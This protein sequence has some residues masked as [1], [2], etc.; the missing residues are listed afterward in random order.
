M[1]MLPPSKD[2]NPNSH[3]MAYITQDKVCR[4]CFDLFCH[5]F[6]VY[7]ALLDY[8]HLCVGWGSDPAS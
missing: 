4:I 1:L 3:Y 7:L 5:S 8:S 2:G 6:V